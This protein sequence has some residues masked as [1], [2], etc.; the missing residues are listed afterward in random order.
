MN[1][2]FK[3]LL[4]YD[5]IAVVEA[6]DGCLKINSSGVCEVCDSLSH[7][8][9]SEGTCKKNVIENCLIS[10]EKGICYQCKYNYLLSGDFLCIPL[11]RNSHLKIKGCNYHG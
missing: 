2:I 6:I 7:Y 1:K 11:E 10:F 8:I 5:I 3:F 9:L 4:I